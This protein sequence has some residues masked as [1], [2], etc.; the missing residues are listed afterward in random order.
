[1]VRKA[2]GSTLLVLLCA[3]LPPRLLAQSYPSGALNAPHP[4][5]TT[6]FYPGETLEQNA[7]EQVSLSTGQLTSSIPILSLPQQGGRKLE[8]GYV[9]S[10]NTWSAKE[11]SVAWGQY[12]SANGANPLT[13]WLETGAEVDYQQS[14]GGLRLNIPFLHADLLYAGAWN[15]NALGP[16]YPSYCVTDWTFTDWQGSSHS[17]RGYIGCTSYAG[18]TY[19]PPTWIQQTEA[20]DDS[21]YQFDATSATDLKVIGPDGVVYHFNGYQPPPSTGGQ[22]IVNGSGYQQL[23]FPVGQLNS[24]VDPNGNT[25]TF[26]NG[27]ITD[28]TGRQIT[29]TPIGVS[30]NGALSSGGLSWQYQGSPSSGL[31]TASVTQFDSDSQ[32]AVPFPTDHVT[33]CQAKPVPSG[34]AAAGEG[35]HGPQILFGPVPTVY[36]YCSSKIVLQDSTFYQLTFD[37]L[38]R[39]TKIRYPSG[40]YTRYDYDLGS[41]IAGHSEDEGDLMCSHPRTMVVAKH[42]CTLASGACSPS[43]TATALTCQPGVGSGGEATTCYGQYNPQAL[44]GLV[45]TDPQF[46][47]AVYTFSVENLSSTSGGFGDV[48]LY[49]PPL[50]QKRQNYS[51][52]NNTPLRT[53]ETGYS[54]LL[55]CPTVTQNGYTL[56]FRENCLAVPSSLKTTYNDGSPA[57]GATESWQTQY[58]GLR[59]SEIKRDFGGN[60]IVS[61]TTAYESGGIYAVLP[62]ATP[63]LYHILD[64]IQSTSSSES[65]TGKRLT[66]TNT[67]DTV[68]NLHQVDRV[69][70]PAAH[71][72]VTF[73]RDG[74]GNVI[75]SQDPMEFAG[76]HSGSTTYGYTNQSIPGCPTYAGTGLPTLTTNALNQSVKVAFS[77]TGSPMCTQDANGAITK[78][79]Y[80]GFGRSTEKDSA[81]GGKTTLS[82]TSSTPL[83]VTKTVLQDASDSPSETTISD[84]LGRATQHT[85]SAPEGTICTEAFYD[86]VGNISAINDPRIG[87]NGSIAIGSSRTFR[88]DGLGRKLSQTNEDGSSKRWQYSGTTSL[89]T[90]EAGHSIQHITDALGRLVTVNE[91]NPSGNTVVPTI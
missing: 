22:L 45:V 66:T 44:N 51:A 54:A 64:H 37:S 72:T 52:G 29:L 10:S 58:P 77:P 31:S 30:V 76:Q 53:V 65:A 67:Y 83:S 16:F 20:T 81:D 15:Q 34:N 69:A 13:F 12:G 11:T 4:D 87:C 26:S 43:P 27:L 28:T 56:S 3:L 75:Q 80:D 33:S 74:Q 23:N 36:S 25:V 41:P 14:Q 8:L 46:N 63:G 90:D 55:G 19:S 18:G 2:S 50:E 7:R 39:L 91:P 79:S 88:Y 86:S 82:Y 24:M 1:M 40:G 61:L 89:S 70:T 6:G 62:P 84:G 38:D 48:A 17:F 59:T 35:Y 42:Q 78:M 5:T 68:G 60:A 21:G 73:G 47:Q 49:I 9:Y 57:Q 71:A 85:V 32:V